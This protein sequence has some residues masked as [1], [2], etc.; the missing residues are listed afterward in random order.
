MG[1]PAW[2]PG[3]GAHHR[4]G[5]ANN[6]NASFADY[7][8]MTAD[9]RDHQVAAWDLEPPW[10][11]TTAVLKQLLASTVIERQIFIWSSADPAAHL[12]RK[13]RSYR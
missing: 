11:Y 13:V 9:A 10:V 2:V 4:D 3:T 12:I 1:F 7:V 5:L 6:E 8:L